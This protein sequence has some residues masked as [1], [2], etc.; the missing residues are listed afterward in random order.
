MLY[1]PSA[2]VGLPLRWSVARS[3]CGVSGTVGTNLPSLPPIQ[4]A[5]LVESAAEAV[6]KRGSALIGCELVQKKLKT[7]TGMKTVSFVSQNHSAKLRL[8][9]IR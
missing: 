7:P 8:T 6:T 9:S 1:G 2:S 5:E 4:P 3:F